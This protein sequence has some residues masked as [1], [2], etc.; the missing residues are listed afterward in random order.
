MFM[1]AEV[2]GLNQNK[3]IAKIYAFVLWNLFAYMEN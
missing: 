2:W 1:P 3:N